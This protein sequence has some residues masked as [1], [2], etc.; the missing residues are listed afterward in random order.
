MDRRHLCVRR[1]DLCQFSYANLVSAADT[2][3]TECPGL[4]SRAQYSDRLTIVSPKNVDAGGYGQI[5]RHV[6]LECAPQK[7]ILLS[8]TFP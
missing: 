3:R 7:D 4:H 8:S 2:L 1:L 6:R 5:A